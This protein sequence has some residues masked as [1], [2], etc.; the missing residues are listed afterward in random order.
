M[1]ARRNHKSIIEYEPKTN[2]FV[3]DVDEAGQEWFAVDEGIGAEQAQSKAPPLKVSYYFLTIVIIGLIFA[4]KLTNLQI[5]HGKD[6]RVSAEGNR[7]RTYLT[8]APRGKIVDRNDNV[9][10]DN[11]ANYIVEVYPYNMPDNDDE[12]NRAIATIKT[13]T[14]IETDLDATISTAKTTSF[15]PIT[16]VEGITRNEATK[17]KILLR[18]ISAVNVS[19]NP[20]RTYPLDL[21]LS[22][23]IG[24]V[25]KMSETDVLAH[26]DYPINSLIGKSGIEASYDSYLR[27][28]SGETQVEIDSSGKIQ[29][30][31]KTTEP[32]IG[33]TLKLY[34]DNDMQKIAVAT[35]KQALTDNQS[36]SGV[37]L[38]IDVKTGGIRTMVSLPDYDPNIFTGKIDTDAY[39]ALLNDP[40]K[41]LLNRVIAGLYPPGST[42]KPVV[43]AAALDAGVITE[44]TTIETPPEI[45]IGEW[46]FPDWKAHG[47]ANVRKAIAESNNIF[48][49][50]LGGGYSSI[51]GLGAELL[52]SYY[53]KFGLD[54]VT[55]IDI[56]GESNGVV[57]DPEWKE[58]ALGESW[59]I[60]DS[61]HVAIGQGNLLV[62]PLEL[63][64]TTVA[65][66]NNGTLYEP[67]LVE[68]VLSPDTGE[69]VTKIE[70]KVKAENFIS[71]DAIR[72]VREGMR[73]TITAGSGLSTFG[74]NFPI[75]VAGKTGTAQFGTEGKT[76]AWFTSFA[77]YDNPE[78]AI[79]IF[80]EGGGEGYK[81]AAPIAKT[82]FEWYVNHPNQ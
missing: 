62:T 79:C 67:R 28:K 56:P 74:T 66:A 49:Y 22:A 40:N 32:T 44:N 21:G 25:G 46:I 81:V 2:H 11:T 39:N 42:I 14:G 20:K 30:F 15:Y 52:A 23:L 8:E 54:T 33:Q 37:A 45:K 1:F 4:L 16:I 50:A 6:Y 82:L 31:I 64:M 78:I 19:A 41:P 17:Y 63:A 76:H 43:A 10:A 38:V 51:K 58:Q 68:S 69:V 65:I 18:N 71:Q 75:A 12:Y 36:T 48:F 61:Y 29:R 70:P 34:L 13:V 7:L 9:V 73:Q 24:Y 3:A 80:I 26:P 55:G 59:Y 53:R 47:S 57:P 27:G 35:L 77:P 5:T 72:V 60:G